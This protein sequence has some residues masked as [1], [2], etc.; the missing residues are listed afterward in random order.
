M[1]TFEDGTASGT[2]LSAKVNNGGSA[3]CT[4]NVTTATES[5]KVVAKFV[6]PVAKGITLS[7]ATVKLGGKEAISFGASQTLEGKV[8]NVKKTAVVTGHALTASTFGDIVGSDGLAYA[9]ADK[10]NLPSG[11]T[12][13][14]MVAYVGSGAETSTTYNHGL[15]LALKDATYTQKWSNSS[16]EPCL[17]AQHSSESDAKGDMAGIANTD[18]L[19]SHTSH[20]HAAA[21]AARNYQYAD[22]VAVGAHPEEVTSAWFLPSAGQ[23]QKMAAAA[24]GSSNLYTKASLSQY[25]WSSSEISAEEAW[26]FGAYL[27]EYKKDGKNYSHSVRACLAF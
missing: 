12:A 4:A 20:T 26:Y 23:W 17:P 9:A 14:A 22:G 2:T 27:V 19:V 15:A 3:I 24:G 5:E 13:V 1:I 7:S 25:Y 6:L 16:S 10:D 11:V 18:A 21:S 8:Y